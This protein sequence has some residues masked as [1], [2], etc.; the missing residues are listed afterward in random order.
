[1]KNVYLIGMM[2]SGKTVTGKALAEIL[3]A[4]FADLDEEIE[5]KT[6]LTVNA[7]FE[8]QGE[9]YF[10]A[11]E[12]ERLREKAG[13]SGQV[14]ATGGG[15]ILAADNVLLMRGSGVIVYLRTPLSV[16]EKR[17]A[18]KKDRP[19]LNRPNPREA[20]ARIFH[21]RKALYESSFDLAVDTEGKSAKEVAGLI[22]ERLNPK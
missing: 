19:L 1:M 6:G 22:I 2:G 17:L 3:G 9:P 4:R 20:L 18:E 11:I 8:T 15:I 10:R 7:I 14:V 21:D 16:L 5:K 12:R 13:V